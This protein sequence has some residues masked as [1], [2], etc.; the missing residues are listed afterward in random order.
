[1]NRIC[2]LPDRPRVRPRIV[3]IMMSIFASLCERGMNNG[4]GGCVGCPVRGLGRLIDAR[5]PRVRHGHEKR[6]YTAPG[7]GSVSTRY[8]PPEWD[9]YNRQLSNQVDDLMTGRLE[10]EKG[11]H[12]F[13]AVL[14]S[15][16]TS[17]KV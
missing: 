1:M 3:F 15:D 8:I 2:W 13:A 14:R 6:S 9:I 17:A 7:P 4:L 10:A 16:R 12:G 5:T 11:C